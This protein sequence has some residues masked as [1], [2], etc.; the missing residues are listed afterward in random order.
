MRAALGWAEDGA[1][2]TEPYDGGAALAV[3]AP[4]ERLF[5]ATELNEWAWQGAAWTSLTCWR[6]SPR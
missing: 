6:R 4:R 2:V 5:A 3:A 1:I